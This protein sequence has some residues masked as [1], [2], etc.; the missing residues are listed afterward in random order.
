MD[1]NNTQ[2]IYLQLM[3][4]L[5]EQ[6]STGQLQPN[7]KLPSVRE[8]ASTYKVNPNTVQRSYQELEREG[9]VYTQRGVGSFVTEDPELVV[10]MR[11]SMAEE[12]VST[13][14]EDMG[15]LGYTL[16]QMIETLEERRA[17]NVHTS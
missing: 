9:I 2:P 13:F 17:Q 6:I 16:I 3:I 5:K 11:K 14:I 7:E 4:L 1:F 8:I 10:E 15:N 12:L